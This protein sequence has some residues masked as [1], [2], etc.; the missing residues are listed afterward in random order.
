MFSPGYSN[1]EGPVWIDGSLYVSQI[2]GGTNPPASRILQITGSTV[3]VFAPDTGTNGLAVDPNGKLVGARH[4]DGSISFIDLADPTQI[5]PIASSYLG[6]RFNS[7]NDLAI[8]SD[9]NIYFSD[10]E[11]QAPT[12]APQGLNHTRV[13]RID[14]SKNVTSIA[15]N[16]DQ[17][18]GVTLSADENTLYVSGLSGLWTY[19]VQADGSTGTGTQVASFLAGSDGMGMDC[20]GNLYITQAKS[21]IV[22]DPNGIQIGSIAVNPPGNVTNVAFGGPEHRTLFV[23]ALGNDPGLWTVELQVPGLPY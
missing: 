12:P 9:G 1:V 14:P 7:P 3:V 16:L 2:A 10:P 4:A 6:I 22:L 19:P 23:T 18:N 11:W 20:A 21:V 15:E 17:P 8:R 13:Y 5:T